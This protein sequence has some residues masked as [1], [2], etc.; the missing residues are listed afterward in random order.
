MSFEFL[1]VLEE[2]DDIVVFGICG[3]VVL[4]FWC[5][6]WCG[7]FDDGMDMFGDDVI[8]FWYF[9]D[10]CEYVVFFVCFVFVCV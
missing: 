5:Y 2:V 7:G 8:W 6:I 1:R 10:F 4:G 9:G 3:Y